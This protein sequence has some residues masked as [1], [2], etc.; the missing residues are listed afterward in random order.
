MF[1]CIVVAHFD[2]LYYPVSVKLDITYMITDFLFD[3]AKIYLAL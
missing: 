2:N 3:I 1:L